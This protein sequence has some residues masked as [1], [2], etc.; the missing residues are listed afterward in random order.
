M[1]T[2]IRIISMVPEFAERYEIYQI[3]ELQTGRTWHT[4]C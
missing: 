1:Q 3:L 4:A 2:Q